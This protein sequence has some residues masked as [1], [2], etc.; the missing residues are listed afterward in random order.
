MEWDI[1]S[2]SNEREPLET[3]R[4]HSQPPLLGPYPTRTLRKGTA[5]RISGL[6][7]IVDTITSVS[8][9]ER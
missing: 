9:G 6:F 8:D 7:L 5:P 4:F 3:L 2:M 1:A